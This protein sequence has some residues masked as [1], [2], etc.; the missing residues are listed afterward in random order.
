MKIP[1]LQMLNDILNGNYSPTLHASMRALCVRT[2]KQ[3]API[4][5]IK[6]M[7]DA[8]LREHGH[9]PGFDFRESFFFMRM[10]CAARAGQRETERVVFGDASGV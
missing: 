2:L 6:R 7:R 3:E 10:R 9:P 4:W 8:R 1:G 5:A